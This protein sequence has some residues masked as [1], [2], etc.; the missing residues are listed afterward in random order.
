MDAALQRELL[1]RARRAAGYAYAPYSDFPVGAAVLTADGSILTGCNVENASIGLTICAE[2]AAICAA[3]GAGH[4]EI[5][6]V[7]VSAPKSARTTPCGACRQVLNEFRPAA[8]DMTVIL[9]DGQSGEA[10]PLGELFPAAF[11]P[12]NVEHAKGAARDPTNRGEN[13]HA[14]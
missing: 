12:R 4:R 7:A 5:T 11:G 8:R 9:D 10:I 13:D 14:W 3:V 1:T 2:R 6:A